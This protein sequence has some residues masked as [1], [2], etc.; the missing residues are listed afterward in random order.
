MV[1]GIDR[2][3]DEGGSES[4][5]PGSAWRDWFGH[6]LVRKKGLRGGELEMS[7]TRNSYRHV[8]G[9]SQLVVSEPLWSCCGRMQMEIRALHIAP[10]SSSI[11][12]KLKD[13]CEIVKVLSV[14]RAVLYCL[15]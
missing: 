10:A 11:S 5:E 9:K 3:V 4:V 1:L 13:G 7:F 15:Y 14:H 12:K 6:G 8:E 2:D